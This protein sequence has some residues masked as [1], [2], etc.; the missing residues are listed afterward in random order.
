MLHTGFYNDFQ[1]GISR[2]KLPSNERQF[3]VEATHELQRTQTQ[4]SQKHHRKGY[5]DS[6][7]VGLKEF[8]LT[9]LHDVGLPERRV[10]LVPYGKQQTRLKAAYYAQL[11]QSFLF[12]D[13]WRGLFD[14]RRLCIALLAHS[15]EFAGNRK[16]EIPSGSIYAR[17]KCAVVV[18]EQVVYAQLG[19]NGRR[20][21]IPKAHLPIE[22]SWIALIDY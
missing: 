10:W 1:I 8:G 16:H 14:K 18:V 15:L 12:F 11:R 4:C 17:G 5:A 22:P 6:A 9:I 13:E 7:I 19:T 20:Y 3:V 21:F 2:L